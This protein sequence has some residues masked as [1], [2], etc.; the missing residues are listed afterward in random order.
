[1][2]IYYDNNY[3]HDVQIPLAMECIKKNSNLLSLFNGEITLRHGHFCI[4]NLGLEG[5]KTKP[6]NSEISTNWLGRDTFYINKNNTKHKIQELY[7]L[8]PTY[9]LIGGNIS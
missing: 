7:G 8:L 9:Y 6:W 1:M 5:E 3:N 4:E 2:G